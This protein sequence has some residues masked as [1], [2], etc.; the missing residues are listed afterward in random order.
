MQ[1]YKTWTSLRAKG[2]VAV[3]DVGGCD[4]EGKTWLSM[5]NRKERPSSHYL[6]F[7]PKRAKETTKETEEKDMV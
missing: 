4:G 5:A 3:A 7:K 6:A 1:I 2:D